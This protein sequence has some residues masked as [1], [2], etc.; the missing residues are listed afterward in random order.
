[1]C[2]SEL[3]CIRACI[4]ARTIAVWAPFDMYICMYIFDM[5]IY[6]YMCTSVYIYVYICIYL[7]VY[8]YIY[9]NI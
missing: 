2:V 8:I 3:V 4:C 6:V 9:I 1:M 7:Y 5:Y